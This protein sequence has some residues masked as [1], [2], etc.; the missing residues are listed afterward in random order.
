M[1]G[2]GEGKKIHSHIHNLG[3]YVA[4]LMFAWAGGI[5]RYFPKLWIWKIRSDTQPRLD[6]CAAVCVT[7]FSP[8]IM[9]EATYF[10]GTCAQEHPLKDQSTIYLLNW[11]EIQ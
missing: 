8:Y 4:I 10:W 3:K 6:I 11:K 9:D 2:I 1:I 5:A 7:V